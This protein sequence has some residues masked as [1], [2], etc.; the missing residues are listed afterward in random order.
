MQVD[1]SETRNTEGDTRFPMQQ[2]QPLPLQPIQPI[3]PLPIPP[4]HR[5]GIPFPRPPDNR[6]YNHFDNRIIRK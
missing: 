4:I 2:M 5:P 3:Q 6:G 1:S